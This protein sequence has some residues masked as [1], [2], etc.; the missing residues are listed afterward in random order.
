M[1][2]YET[3][4]TRGRTWPRRLH[5]P[6]HALGDE[7]G[8]RVPEWAQHRSVFRGAGRTTYLVETDSLDAA[9]GDLEQL[10]TNGWD[11]R[12]ERS[13]ADDVARVTLTQRDVVRAA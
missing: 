13:G 5:T 11:V 3:H 12:I 7:H 6:Y 4:R 10:A 1:E 9:Q 8:V 2:H